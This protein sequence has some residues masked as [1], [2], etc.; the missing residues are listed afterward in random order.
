MPSSE[1]YQK[2]KE[3]IKQKTKAH[4]LAHPEQYHGYTLKY[5]KQYFELKEIIFNL[6][7][8][9]CS[10]PNCSTPGGC[11]DKRCLQI[12]HIK[13][14]GRQDRLKNTGY[15]ISK[16]K[17]IIDLIKSNKNNQY[18]L[19]CANCNWIKMWENNER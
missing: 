6:L 15:K 2:N 18:Q 16:L 8:N 14:G 5:R 17:E 13:G 3:I 7:G 10:N 1:Y 4:R 19:L 9:R 12:D 11:M